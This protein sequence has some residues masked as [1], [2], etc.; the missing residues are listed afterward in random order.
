LP[1]NKFCFIY[2][3]SKEKNQFENKTN[4]TN[5]NNIGE[6]ISSGIFLIVCVEEEEG[7]SISIR[8]PNHHELLREENYKG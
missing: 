1:L 4:K 5:N 2:Y 8:S 3:C 6:K 7:C